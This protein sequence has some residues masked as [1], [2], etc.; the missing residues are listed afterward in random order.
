MLVLEYEGDKTKHGLWSLSFDFFER[1]F[2]KFLKE[3]FD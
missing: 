2:N 3:L 1:N